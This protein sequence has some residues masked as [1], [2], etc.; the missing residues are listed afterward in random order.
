[1]AG[2]II[3]RGD[4]TWLVRVFMGRDEQG[5]RRYINKTI[6][7]TK[8]DADKYL[9]ST[10]TA[11]SAGT[12]VEPTPLTVNAYL[13]KWLEAAARPHLTERTFISYQW[14]LKQHVRPALGDKKLAD[15]RPLHV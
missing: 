15:V 13:D 11:I 9:N 7:G 1:M 10:L 4:K 3:K 5:K 12:F 8:K 6:H 2:Q 14:L